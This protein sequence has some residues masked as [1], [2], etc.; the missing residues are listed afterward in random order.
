MADIRVTPIP[1]VATMLPSVMLY[2]VM[3]QSDFNIFAPLK[4]HRGGHR[5][6]AGTEIQEAVSQ[7]FH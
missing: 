7:W 2:W 6:P 1:I 4:K 5:C 3:A